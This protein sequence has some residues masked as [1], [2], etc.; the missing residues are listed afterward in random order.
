ML[1]WLTEPR[2][3][4]RNSPERNNKRFCYICFM[5]NFRHFFEWQLFGV[6]TALGERFRISITRIRLWFIY[7]SFLTF[8][9]PMIVYF[10]LAFVLNIR[11][12]I[13]SATR[14]PLRWF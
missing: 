3:P 8:G 1:C 2:I 14:N 7:I 9:S 12:Y 11:Q 4:P 10:I 13:L 5:Q 6:C